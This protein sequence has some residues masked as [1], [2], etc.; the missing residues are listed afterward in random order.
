MLKMHR[1]I[2]IRT[3]TSVLFVL[4][5][6]GMTPTAAQSVDAV[7]DAMKARYQQ[8]LETVDT[9]VIETNQYTSYYRKTTR[10]GEPAYETEMRWKGE[11]SGLFS[12]AG[13]MPSLQPSLSQLDTLAQVS[14]YEGTE[15]IDGRRCHVLRIDDPAALSE[16][17]MPK[18]A[19]E[20]ARQGET[21]LYIDAERYVPLRMESEVT[22]EQRGTPQTVR[23]RIFFSDYRTTDGLTLP[24]R[25]E[26]KMENLNASISPEEREQA[27]QSLEEMEARMEQLSEEQRQMMEGMMKSQLEQ[28]RTILDEGAINFM[29]EVQ[30]VT[31]NAPLPDDAFGGTRN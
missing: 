15:T 1:F 29:V 30:S 26:M 21:R 14:S 3:A 18:S 13:S 20:T 19:A 2:S 9:Y 23:P 8:Q 22:V 6:G 16:R 17:P 25:M 11:G 10:N 27:R 12:G 31:V 5:L 4:L 7:V 24:W 28:L